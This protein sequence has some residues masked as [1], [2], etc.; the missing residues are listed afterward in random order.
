MNIHE[1]V[2]FKKSDP[3][4]LSKEGFLCFDMHCHTRHSDSYTRVYSI[5]KKA[6]KNS[7]G[8]SITDHNC[9]KGAL[10]AWKGKGKTLVI[11][12]IEL[13]CKEG[14]HV[15]IYFYD[16]SSLKEFHDKHVEGRKKKNP[17]MTTKIGIEELL[18]IL[19]NF[20]CVTSI[21]HPMAPGPI[22]FYRNLKKGIIDK[23]V[24]K[25]IDCVEVMCGINIRPRNERALVWAE[26]LKKGFT[27]GS[28]CHM[29][30]NCG[31]VITFSE[32]DDIDS[33]LK[34]CV[35]KQ[36]F[37][38]GSETKLLSKALASTSIVRTHSKYAKHMIKYQ[39]DYTKKELKYLGGKL[40]GLRK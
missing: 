17:F 7:F 26:K 12:G 22:N 32:S 9:I 5:L 39:F 2:K 3:V 18:E 24:M 21:A 34:D 29:L 38:V 6:R 31:Q 10:D 13:G 23:K 33:F 35:K 28:D 1:R 25:S 27:G 11:P 40:K 37:I 15:L 4:D 20:N 16:V 14:C 30:R 19:K 8:V 36:N